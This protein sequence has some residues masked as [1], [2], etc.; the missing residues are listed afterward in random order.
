MYTAYYNSIPIIRQ[1]VL[2]Y[3]LRHG[4]TTGITQYLNFSVT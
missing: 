1:L 2:S 4:K 3:L